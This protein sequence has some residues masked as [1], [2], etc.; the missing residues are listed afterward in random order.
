MIDIHSHI[1][2]GIDDGAVSLEDSINIVRELSE[3]GVTDI[4]AT[5]HFVNETIYT[6]PRFMNKA[7]LH[8]LAQSLSDEG[9]EVNLYLGNEIYIDRDIPSLLRSAKISALNDSEYLLVELPMSGEYPNSEDI[10]SELIN[11]GHK[12]ILAHPERYVSFQNDSKKIQKYSE[13]GVLFQ[14]NMGSFIRQYGKHSE[15]LAL[16]LAKEDQIFALGSDIHHVRGD[17]SISQAKKKLRKYYTE[18]EL[19]QILVDNP[20]KIVGG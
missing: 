8:R 19:H 1:L 16:K 6:S 7:L 20:G 10:L 9:I 4:I 13:L 11:M 12:V 2:P 18:R 15:K 17:D 3:Q 5:P 14:C